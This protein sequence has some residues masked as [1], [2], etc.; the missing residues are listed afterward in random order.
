M[1]DDGVDYRSPLAGATERPRRKAYSKKCHWDICESCSPCGWTSLLPR[2]TILEE[3]LG[4]HL[5]PRDVTLHSRSPSSRK[6]TT[7]GTLERD[8]SPWRRNV[9]QFNDADQQRI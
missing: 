8:R 7:W 4:V 9:D 6:R 2:S 5:I 1:L 3:A